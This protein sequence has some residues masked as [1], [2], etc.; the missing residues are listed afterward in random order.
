MQLAALEQSPPSVLKAMH[1]F[2]CAGY[3]CT[4]TQTLILLVKLA[5]CIIHTS[6]NYACFSLREPVKQSR[7]S[8]QTPLQ[9][10]LDARR[11]RPDSSSIP[12]RS[13]HIPAHPQAFDPC[14]SGYSRTDPIRLMQQYQDSV[15][16]YVYKHIDGTAFRQSMTEPSG[17]KYS[18]PIRE[19]PSLRGDLLCLRFRDSGFGWILRS[20]RLGDEEGWFSTGAWSPPRI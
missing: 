14:L 9:A 8:D 10:Q 17:R 20:N 19:K 15:Q 7:L 6:S 2:K 3:L 13:F 12:W 4:P 5:P 11:R 16:V 18:K 1:A